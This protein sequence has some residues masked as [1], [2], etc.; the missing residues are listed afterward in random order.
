M[1]AR[2][3]NSAGDRDKPEL[4]CGSG[5]RC[6]VRLRTNA[7]ASGD[8]GAE[9]ALAESI[10]VISAVA[11]VCGERT[12]GPLAIRYR[13]SPALTLVID[14][15][16]ASALRCAALALVTVISGA[17]PEQRDEVGLLFSS[18]PELLTLLLLV[19]FPNWPG[20]VLWGV[21]EP[22][23]PSTVGPESRMP[24]NNAG[25]PLAFCGNREDEVSGFEKAEWVDCVVLAASAI[26]AAFTRLHNASKQPTAEYIFLNS[27]DAMRAMQNWHNSRF[28]KFLSRKLVPQ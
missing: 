3:S 27:F 5:D 20:S 12:S 23:R 14:G 6:Q 16:V 9:L 11:C 28:D 15:K 7:S 25:K 1:P 26:S 18:L 19:D 10:G 21:A 4:F 2:E 22:V 8:A 17:Y 13:A 24:L